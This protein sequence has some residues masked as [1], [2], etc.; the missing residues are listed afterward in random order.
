MEAKHIINT[1]QVTEQKKCMNITYFTF[2]HLYSQLKTS[3]R[4]DNMINHL[5]L[6]IDKVWTSE[7]IQFIK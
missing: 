1:T 4:I 7:Q 3:P 2:V 6:D 5:Y